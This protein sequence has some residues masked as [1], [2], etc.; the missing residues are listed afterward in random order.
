MNYHSEIRIGLVFLIYFSS[1]DVCSL[2]AMARLANLV[3][4]SY[5][6]DSRGSAPWH[7]VHRVVERTSNELEYQ[8]YFAM[9]E[10]R[11]E[12]GD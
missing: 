2:L 11:Q 8:N 10:L 4:A 5:S 12:R 6:T 1:L 3:P 9:L 7:D